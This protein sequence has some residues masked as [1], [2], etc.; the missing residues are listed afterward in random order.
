MPNK[1][2][3]F[4]QP[5]ILRAVLFLGTTSLI[6]INVYPHSNTQCDCKKLSFQCKQQ[7]QL[8]HFHRRLCMSRK[9]YMR[10]CNTLDNNITPTHERPC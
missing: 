8:P 1:T 10:P 4:E 2:V 5:S 9:I 7:T 3:Y 6:Q